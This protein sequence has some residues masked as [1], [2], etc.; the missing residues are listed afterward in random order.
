MSPS[1]EHCKQLR[2]VAQHAQQLYAMRLCELVH[3]LRKDEWS[4]RKIAKEVGEPY[5]TVWRII[6]GVK[7]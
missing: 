1:S 4:V 3:F 2:A 5:A 7:K 6:H